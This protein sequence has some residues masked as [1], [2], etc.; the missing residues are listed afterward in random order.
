M[1]RLEW[2]FGSYFWGTFKSRGSR[3]ARFYCWGG[4][5]SRDD[6]RKTH[7]RSAW[8][9][10]DTC[11][12]GSAERWRQLVK[13]MSYGNMAGFYSQEEAWVHFYMYSRY[14]NDQISVFFSHIL[15][16]DVIILLPHTWYTPDIFKMTYEHLY[17]N[18]KEIV[19]QLHLQIITNKLL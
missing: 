8:P 18:Q 2:L 6:V 5:W 17:H 19:M 4:Q 10:Y 7:I 15:L 14:N 1:R 9:Q 11:T 3:C 12:D 16:F 13:R